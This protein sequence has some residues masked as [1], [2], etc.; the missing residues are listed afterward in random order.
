MKFL[1]CLALLGFL[2][3]FG[4]K[5][6]TSGATG[7]EEIDQLEAALAGGDTTVDVGRL[8]EAYRSSVNAGEGSPE[9]QVNFLLRAADL[10][11]QQGQP[12]LAG[13]LLR[14]AVS[15]YQDAPNRSEA[16]GRLAELY[17]TDLQ[18]PVA[19]ATLRELLAGEEIDMPTRM[20]ELLVS[21]T[22]SVSGRIEV[23]RSRDYINTAE[24]WALLNPAAEDAPVYLYKA[25]EVARSIRAFEQAID[26]YAWIYRRYPE[27]ENAPK[28]LFLQAFT[29]EE[30]LND[31]ERA[32]PLYESFIREFPND[33]FA[34]DA[35]ILL[36]N[37]GKSD[38]EIFREFEQQQQES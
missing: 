33:E 21:L 24:A 11:R 12:A 35:Q 28:A 5:A 3:L 38:E 16:A 37:L 34:D 23:L 2:F 36:N 15:E 30:N 19:A 26:L 27:Y 25:A 18:S 17:A 14:Q 29:V 4:C 10:G 1:P 20:Q 8:I 6:D 13:E 32:R 31:P 22:D 7:I 9:Q